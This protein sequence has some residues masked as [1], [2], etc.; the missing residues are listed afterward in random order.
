MPTTYPATAEESA[1][2]TDPFG[3]FAPPVEAEAPEST[4][5]VCGAATDW[6]AEDGCEVCP[7]C[8]E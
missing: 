6:D 1:A 4:C 8:P 5:P 3:P 7:V 2:L